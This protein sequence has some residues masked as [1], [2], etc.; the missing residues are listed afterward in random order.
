MRHDIEHHVVSGAHGIS[1]Y[2]GKV[3]YAAVHVVIYD[4]LRGAHAFSFHG[5]QGGKNGRR[6]ARRYLEGAAGL[7][8]VANHARQVGYHVLHRTTNSLIISTHQIG[9][10]TTATDA[11]HHATTQGRQLAQALLDINGSEMAQR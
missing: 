11:G 3:V 1:P 4:A 9:D 2:R 6:H 8:S 10:A 5:Q 7:G